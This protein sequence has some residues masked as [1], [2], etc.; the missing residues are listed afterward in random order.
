MGSQYPRS[1]N[2][3]KDQEEVISTEDLMSEIDKLN[4][5][6]ISNKEWKKEKYLLAA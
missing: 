6:Q 1:S 5:E 4:R 3:Y 2:G